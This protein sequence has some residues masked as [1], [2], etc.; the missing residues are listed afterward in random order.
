MRHLLATLL[1][2]PT[3]ILL[4]A[5]PAH[6]QQPPP[7]PTTPGLIQYPSLTHDGQ[8]LVFSWLGDLW[9]APAAGGNATR[10][11]SHPAD[12][13]RAVF[14]PDGKSLAFESERDGARN[15][16]LMPITPTTS[17]TP[18]QAGPITRITTSDRPQSLSGWSPAGDAILFS[19][20]N[21]GLQRAARMLAVPIKDGHPAAPPAPITAAFGSYPRPTP[22]A[23]GI[24][25]T[26]RYS[27]FN[28]PR[29]KGSAS[30]DL[31]HLN[32]TT[33]QFTQ[34]TATPGTDADAYPMHDGTVVFLSTRDGTANIWRASID[35]TNPQPL[36][37]FAPTPTN[38]TIAHGVRDLSVNP[39]A[40]KAVFLLFDQLMTLDLAHSD[41]QPT[42][43]TIT[44]APDAQNN[45][46]TRINLARETT[47]ALLSPDGKAIA[48]IARGEVFVRST[49]ENWPTRRV[50]NTP[51]RERELAWSPDGRI[52]WF[53]TDQAGTNHPSY[54]T[55]TLTR[56]DLDEKPKP[57]PAADK[58]DDPKE[59]PREDKKDEAKDEKKPDDEPG[60]TPTADKPADTQ[61]KKT[62]KDKKPDPGKRWAEALAFDVQTLDTSF[63]PPGKNDGVM[64]MELTNP[65]PSPDGRSLLLTRGLGDL[66]LIDLVNK[67]ARVLLEG[68]SPADA[69]WAA[70]S[71]HIVF[72]REDL[73]YNS[74][75]F[76]LDTAPTPPGTPTPAPINLTQHPD[77]D[78]SPRL[79]A[80]G[81]V[82]IFRS[83]RAGE[84]GDFAI[85]AINLDPALDSLL[86]YELDDYYKKQ[87]TA[88]KARKPIDP[89]LWDNP[90]WTAKELAKEASK[91][92]KPLTFDVADAYLRVRRINVAG[93]RVGTVL[94]TP[95]ADRIIFTQ[96]PDGP[97]PAEGTLSSISYKAD[98]RKP[99][100]TGPLRSIT[101]SNTGERVAFIKAGQASAAPT[102]GGKIDPLTID[103]PI[104][105]DLNAQAR[106]K[107]LEAAR[108]I[109]NGFY[110][111]TLKGLDWPALTARYLPLALT[112]RT[113]NEF[114]RVFSML[115]GELD[116][117]HM[118]IY[119]PDNFTP[120]PLAIGYLGVDTKPAESGP[121]DP[122]LTVTRILADGP[123]AVHPKGP[124][125]GD[126]ITSIDAEPTAG[127]D[128][129]TLLI[130]R[131]GRETLLTYTRPGVEKPITIIITPTTSA[132]HADLRY[133]QEVRDRRETVSKLSNN[134]IGYLHV[135][136]M[137]QPSVR[138]FERDLFAAASGKDALIIDVRDNGG[139]TT[140]DILLASLT[141]PVHAKTQPRGVDP[142]TIPPDT[143]PRDR[144]LI[145]SFARPIIVL[146]NENSYSNAEIFAH[147]IQTI[148]RGKL[149]GTPT[150][151]GVISTGSATL[152]DGTTLRTP[153]RGWILPDGRD[154]DANGAQPDINIPSLPQD[155]TIGND[156]QLKAAVQ[157][158]LETIR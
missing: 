26:R 131:A 41:A 47:E 117:S 98:D 146:I 11:T 46:Q 142:S 63:I 10:I 24:V 27:E 151:G 92:P 43:I 115:L 58:K 61:T 69:H 116:A 33:N 17:T 81:K 38:L 112:T 44:A 54:A 55:V 109:G 88:A 118:G 78:D 20:P 80:D 48:Q 23:A 53:T 13:R 132:E 16:Y 148:K 158:L 106:Q 60:A 90:D 153:F 122:G 22:D 2:L 42:P 134:K 119:G 125:P 71:R 85:Y 5:P 68:W 37:R 8:A 120:P 32:T 133:K 76:L 64:G 21:V 34:I 150:Y 149:V 7:A 59:D 104:T 74:D 79:S 39:A 66:I 87:S 145:Y 67:S 136:G 144:R 72:A 97:P 141:A 51:G 110:H 121:T 36:T 105:L 129:Q 56:E 96:A 107:F 18:T 3:S 124:R 1:I 143:Y 111:N 82:L 128:L 155:E 156:A 49:D 14:S 93:T 52:L 99:I 65:I 84:N 28:R 30:S 127:R 45:E 57:D 77:A 91:T 138:D 4:P 152:I 100:T 101:L 35:G 19:E 86:P 12:E 135:R 89:V 31:W 137:S 123:A 40:N 130:A 25:F 140:A 75:I 50:T 126:T 83:D 154:E 70:D 114:D 113:N 95:A 102:L 9:L 6:A 157:D 15:L 29:Y 147:A 103:A 62:K 94:A 108:I 139:G 73:D